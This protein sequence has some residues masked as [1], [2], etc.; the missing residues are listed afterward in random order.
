ME[1]LVEA[2]GELR[3]PV[4]DEELDYSGAPGEVPGQVAGLLGDP[5]PHWLGG[6]T[7]EVDPPGVDLDKEQDVQTLEQHRGVGT[8]V[9]G[10]SSFT[11]ILFGR[12]AALG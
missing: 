10:D 1:D 6:N 12:C 2:G 8:L 5:L 11:P 9:V 7:R 3:V 4:A